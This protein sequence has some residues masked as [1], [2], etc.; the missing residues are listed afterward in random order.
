[1]MSKSCWFA[2]EEACPLPRTSPPPK[3]QIGKQ[4]AGQINLFFGSSVPTARK[5]P[6]QCQPQS[7]HTEVEHPTY[8][9]RAGSSLA[10]MGNAGNWLGQISGA[11][12]AD[13]ACDPFG[14][15]PGNSLISHLQQGSSRT[16]LLWCLACV[17]KRQLGAMYWGNA[18]P[19]SAASTHSLV[20]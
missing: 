8:H 6:S 2:S 16:L 10:L 14:F 11:S 12:H 5:I 1:M 9:L 19:G 20:L 13:P 4:C 7:V 15:V 18:L 17:G 3:D